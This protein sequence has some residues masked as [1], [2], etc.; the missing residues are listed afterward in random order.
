M[1]LDRGTWQARCLNDSALS[2]CV[3]ACAHTHTILYFH[4]LRTLIDIG[5]L[6]PLFLT[7]TTTAKRS[8]LPRLGRT[9]VLFSL[10]WTR[11]DQ[12]S[13]INTPESRHKWAMVQ[14]LWPKTGLKKQKRVQNEPQYCMRGGDTYF[15]CAN[16]ITVKY[17]NCIIFWFAKSNC[18]ALFFVS[19]GGNI[20]LISFGK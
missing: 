9:F 4:L 8:N 14:F 1:I 6:N 19:S 3:H 17:C 2:C 16:R 7:E 12:Q 18:V 10:V 13:K 11:Q 5:I 15:N 20:T